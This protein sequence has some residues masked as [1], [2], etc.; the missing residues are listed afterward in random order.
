[1]S[2]SRVIVEE[3]PKCSN[4]VEGKPHLSTVRKLEKSFV[5]RGITRFSGSI[6]GALLGSVVPGIGTII[7]A[8]VG[9]LISSSSSLQEL[10]D[11]LDDELHEDTVFLFSCPKC[12]QRWEKSFKRGESKDIIPDEVLLQQKNKKTEQYKELSNK[13]LLY[14]VISLAVLL[15]SGWYCY[16]NDC[17]YTVT[18]YSQ[19]FFGLGAGE[20]E[21]TEINYAWIFF[22][23]V[24][25]ISGCKLYSYVSRYFDVS[26]KYE[27]LEKMNVKDYRYS[28]LRYEE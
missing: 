15:Y 14:G 7:G 21:A 5:K 28:K 27:Q 12:A 9:V 4:V 8:I 23:I 22:A 16:S 18:R 3:C 10:V 1:M 11:A 20:Y 26:S 19:G 25:C 24:I 17:F 6:I 13:M 2:K